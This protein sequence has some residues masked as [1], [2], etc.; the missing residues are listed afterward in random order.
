MNKWIIV[1]AERSGELA[2]I[3]YDTEA[4]ATE[5]AARLDTILMFGPKFVRLEE[6]Q[7]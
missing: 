5:A 6:G 4:A 7:G 1:I 2:I 3:T